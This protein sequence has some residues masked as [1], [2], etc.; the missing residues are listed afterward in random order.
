MRR[1]IDD[2]LLEILACPRCDQPLTFENSTLHS[3]GAK[4]E[5]PVI[6]DIPFLFADP[7]VAIDD[8]RSRYHARIREIES[9]IGQL[10]AAL[11]AEGLP[12]STESR[13]RHEIDAL[14][15][16]IDELDTLMKPLDIT[17]LTADHD[18]YLAMRTRLPSDQG[19]STYYANLHRDWCWG[20]EENRVSHDL[21]RS[22]VDTESAGKLLVL[23]SGGSRLAYDLHQSLEP[24]MTVAVDFNPLLMFAANRIMCGEKVDLHEFPLAPMNAASTACARTLSAPT[25]VKPGYFPVLAN[26]LR[27]PFKPGVFDTL[28]TPWLIDVISEPLPLQAARWNRLLKRGG[29]WVWFGSH[30]FRTANPA[31]RFSVEETE[32]ILQAQGFSKPEIV[33]AEIPY[34]VSPANRHARTERVL[35]MSMTKTADAKAPP[36]HVALPDWI[37]R[38]DA[39]VPTNDSFRSQAMS[40]RIHAFLMSMIDG[41]RTISDMAELMESQRL[42]PKDEAEATLRT[43][44]IRMFEEAGSYRAL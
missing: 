9:E 40:T 44:L 10:K 26:V 21:V 6:E 28:V 23:G 12:H 34:M 38:T 15:A 42:M 1:M 29:R 16:H 19:L 41:Q 4:V 22:A 27:A 24:P 32:E 35:V 2:A 33:E 30:V 17:S 36:R 37:V 5:F 43:F 31:H 11:S 7:A 8:W 39:P 13:L 18:T 3:K 25:P 14:T 20:D